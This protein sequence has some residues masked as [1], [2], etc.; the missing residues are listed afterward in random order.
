MKSL[1]SNLRKLGTKSRVVLSAG[2][3]SCAVGILG[4]SR[5]A[6]GPTQV[7]KEELETRCHPAFQ[8]VPRI[9]RTRTGIPGDP[10]NV[11]IVATESQL[12][13]ALL[14]AG[15]QPAD[16]ITL[17]STLRITASTVF[18]RAYA[19]APVSNLYVGRHKQD[20]AFEQVVGKDARRRHH[21]RF[22]KSREVDTAG[23]PLWL[24]A[25]TYDKGVGISHTTGLPT[26][27]IA[28]DVDAERDKL[29]MDLRRA[30]EVGYWFWID[31]FQEQLQGRN[32]GGDPYHT[33]G[34]LA[35]GVLGPA[36]SLD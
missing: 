8:A 2:L 25:A 13:Q 3:V 17:H 23:R 7:G 12:V 14:K 22:W 4:L 28:P 27:H 11:A 35:V 9:T 29:M 24:G 19:H 1:Q 10:V 32:G 5:A 34:R 36:A 21:V 31:H 26:H 20:L 33:D 6:A 30:G 15:W 18:H 16:P